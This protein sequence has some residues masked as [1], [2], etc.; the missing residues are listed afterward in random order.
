MLKEKVDKEKEALIVE[1][2]KKIALHYINTRKR[3]GL[4]VEPIPTTKQ[5]TKEEKY[6]DEFF[7]EFEYEPIIH[8]HVSDRLDEEHYGDDAYE[9]RDCKDCGKMVHAFNNECMN[10]WVE[11]SQGNYCF[12]C[13]YTLVEKYDFILDLDVD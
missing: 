2:R 9:R 10:F 6:P 3:K 5:Q 1:E 11:T 4:P 8:S 12:K 7:L 13:F